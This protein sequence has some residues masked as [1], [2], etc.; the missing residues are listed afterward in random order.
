MKRIIGWAIICTTVGALFS[1]MPISLG[2]VYGLK[3]ILLGLTI[4]AGIVAF[5]ALIELAKKWT[6]E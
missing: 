2:L 1:V 3:G 6:E 4:D 5:I